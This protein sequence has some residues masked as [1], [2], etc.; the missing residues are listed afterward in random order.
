MKP[1]EDNG[2]DE[3]SLGWND[4]G[5][6]GVNT[7][8]ELD[9]ADDEPS[10]GSPNGNEHRS[11]VDGAPD[12]RATVRWSAKTKARSAMT[13]ACRTATASEERGNLPRL[14]GLTIVAR[15]ATA[16]ERLKE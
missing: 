9:E 7:D 11:Q 5:Q 10:L 6:N 3:E 8:R 2:D 4:R 13:R 16:N 12:H 1:R 14:G 15:S